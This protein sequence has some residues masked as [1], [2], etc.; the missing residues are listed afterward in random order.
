MEGLVSPGELLLQLLH[1]CIMHIGMD[2][3]PLHSAAALPAVEDGAI[4]ELGRHVGQISIG[5]NISRVV[6]AKL[7]VKRDCSAGSSLLDSKTA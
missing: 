3:H 7:E 6:T 4:D 5:A 1:K 2:I